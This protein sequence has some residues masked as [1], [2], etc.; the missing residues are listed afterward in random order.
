MSNLKTLERKWIDNFRKSALI[1]SSNNTFKSELAFQV[2]YGKKNDDFPINFP[3]NFKSHHLNFP[4][5]NTADSLNIF[6]EFLRFIGI[7]MQYEKL[8]KFIRSNPSEYKRF[9]DKCYYIFK[10]LAHYGA[11]ITVTNPYKDNY[12]DVYYLLRIE[13]DEIQL[14]IFDE[15]LE[16]PDLYSRFVDFPVGYENDAIVNDLFDKI[17]NT[18]N[19]FF[20]TGKAGTGKSTF[21]QYFAHK[22]KKKL[23]K[24]AFTGIAA[25]NV[26]GQTIHSFFRFP[27]KPL[28]PQDDEITI[29][30]KYSP[31]YNAIKEID[32]IIIDEISM[33][34]SDIVEAIDYSLRNNGGVPEKPFGGKQIIF[35]GDVF[36]L[37]PVVDGRSEI[38][39][40]LFTDIYKSKYFF[41]SPAYKT[42]NPKYFEFKK[43]FRQGND[44]RFVELLDKVRVC[45]IH[46]ELL[47]E[48]NSRHIPTY[49]PKNEDF[50]IT[51]TS[52]NFI[53]TTENTRRLNELDY[54]VFKFEANIT[55]EFKEDRYPTDK[56]L[57][58]KKDSQ[59]I[60]IKNDLSKRWVNGT[61]A[62]IDFISDDI[63]EIRLQDK[64]VHKI[65]KV[66][67]EHRIYNYD[68][69]KRKIVSELKGT[70][71]Q[72]PIKLA[73]AVT[74]HKS[75]GLTF[76]NVI[77]DLGNG[78]FIN[79]QVY[80]G[81]SRCRSLNGIILKNPLRKDDI[82]ADSRIINF[83]ETQQIIGSIDFD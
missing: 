46:S 30:E 34:R 68:R 37:P 49:L 14:N 69:T 26:G 66:T 31:K 23:L 60:F 2:F 3:H 45:D 27:P 41:D 81:L 77:L 32:V 62:K 73:W 40:E 79:G 28:M 5:I 75:Q 64:S 74:I 39:N 17:E 4:N 9:A 1:D 57:A 25:I 67:W 15:P 72:F 33:L 11:N 35:V 24:C 52:N 6:L 29:F 63:I 16:L 44:L 19:S 22:T 12:K 36:Q 50:V 47:E 51:L 10:M 70:F 18:N 61:I 76:D 55:G 42:L 38:E 56:T 20:I 53:A 54:T 82:I 65:E 59:I 7:N 58:L 8:E 71:A 80:T 21:V 83:Y 78:A 48:I 13:C 43:S